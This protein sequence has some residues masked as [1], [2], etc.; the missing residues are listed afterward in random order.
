MAQKKW[1]DRLLLFIVALVIVAVVIGGAIWSASRS[2]RHPSGILG[3]KRGGD[4]EAKVTYTGTQILV[5]NTSSFD[6]LD[7]QMEINALA[8][9]GYMTTAPMVKSNSELNAGLTLFRKPNGTRFN[10]GS[11]IIKFAI[12]SHAADGSVNGVWIGGFD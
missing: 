9:D 5:S 4:L 3:T 11:K 12:T 6:W 10:P 1:Q 2:S 7:V 8:S